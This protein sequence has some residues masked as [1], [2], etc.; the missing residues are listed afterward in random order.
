MGPHNSSNH[1]TSDKKD[2]PAKGPFKYGPLEV[3]ILWSTFFRTDIPRTQLRYLNYSAVQVNN[4][5]D[6]LKR[7]GDER[8]VAFPQPQVIIQYYDGQSG[9]LRYAEAVRDVSSIRGEM[10]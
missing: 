4:V 6:N 9:E 3:D 10:T 1:S 2:R 5:F 8:W 7:V